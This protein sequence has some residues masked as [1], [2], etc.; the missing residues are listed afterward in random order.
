MC[1]KLHCMQVESLKMIVLRHSLCPIHDVGEGAEVGNVI[2]MMYNLFVCIN[3]HCE[4][5][6]RAPHCQSPLSYCTECSLVLRNK[7]RKGKKMFEEKKYCILIVTWVL[8]REIN[9]YELETRYGKPY[10]G[11]IIHDP[12]SWDSFM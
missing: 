7:K 11:A 9:K 10:T 2:M 5:V 1:A 12:V 4:K 6:E 3:V 8:L